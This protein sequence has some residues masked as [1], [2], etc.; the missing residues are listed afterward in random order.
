MQ[1][2]KDASNGHYLYYV[3]Y[4]VELLYNMKECNNALSQ[5]SIHTTTLGMFHAWN[6]SWLTFVSWIL[7]LS[8]PYS[9]D[10][11]VFCIKNNF[12]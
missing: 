12:H 3:E 2:W 6:A 9:S 11:Y 1:Q 4:V 7:I 5:L 10:S 8:E